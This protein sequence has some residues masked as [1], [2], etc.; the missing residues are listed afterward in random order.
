MLE[1]ETIISG[2]VEYQRDVCNY[3]EDVQITNCKKHDLTGPL[4]PT[5]CEECD[6]THYFLNLA[7]GCLPCDDYK[8]TP[9]EFE[10]CRTCAQDTSYDCTSCLV[11]YSLKTDS[12]GKDKC[13]LTHCKEGNFTSSGICTEC[14][15][16]FVRN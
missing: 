6:D 5:A 7:D 16:G 13:V 15:E 4:A 8:S 2:G 9:Q 3:V 12:N 11:G 1:K 10:G 14:L